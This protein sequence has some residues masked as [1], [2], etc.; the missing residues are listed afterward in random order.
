MKD[1]DESD[2]P[3]MSGMPVGFAIG[4]TESSASPVY[5]SPV[6]K[7]DLVMLTFPG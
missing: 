6:V 3:D 7:D 1:S 2:E 5:L 4:V